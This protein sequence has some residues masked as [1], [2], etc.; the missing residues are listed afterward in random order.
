MAVKTIL[1]ATDY[2]EASHFALSIATCL[3]RQTG[4]HLLIAHVS[5]R[6]LY[7]VGELFDEDPEP[8]EKE[9]ERLNAVIP[10]DRQV[11]YEH[12]LLYGKTGST[13]TVRPADEILALAEK[14]RPEAIV[15]GTHGQS[16][17]ADL[18][19]GS[20]AQSVVRRACCPVITVKQPHA[21]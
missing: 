8:D 5:D 20:V 11:E 12:R 3:A 18:L 19:M 21:M 1:Y 16:G 4:A 2:S 9:L 6:E 13:A 7:P 14:E 10:T 17:L 15:I